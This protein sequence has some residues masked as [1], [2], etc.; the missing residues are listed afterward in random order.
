MLRSMKPLSERTLNLLSGWERGASAVAAARL[1]LEKMLEPYAGDPLMTYRYEHSLRVAGWGMKIAQGEGWNAESLVIAC[2]LHD[3]GYPEC[4]S[5]EDF[6]HHPEISA[7]VAKLFLK[8]IGFA[9]EESERICRAIQ[10]H[11]LWDDVP[12]DASEF[13]LS[14]RD[15]D[16][17]DRFDVLR[18]YRDGGRILGNAFICD[19]SAQQIMEECHKELHRI[20]DA[21]QRM[22]ATGTAQRLWD[23]QIE[24]RRN[25][26]IALLEQMRH[27]HVMESLLKLS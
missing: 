17:L 7:R 16:D 13:E 4:S 15:A 24:G 6:A 22:C 14:V 21:E 3:V 25:Y 27:T 2:L 23:A 19:R 1:F 26:Y 20:N 10:F 12:E 11:A 5:D 18:T 9:A 8:R